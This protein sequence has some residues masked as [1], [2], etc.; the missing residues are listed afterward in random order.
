MLFHKNCSG[1]QTFCCPYTLDQHQP[2]LGVHLYFLRNVVLG[3]RLLFSYMESSL[4]N[5]TSSNDNIFKTNTVKWYFITVWIQ[6]FFLKGTAILP[7]YFS[8]SL[9]FL[10]SHFET[11]TV[12][13]MQASCYFLEKQ[14]WNQWLILLFPDF[15]TVNIP[16]QTRITKAG[17]E[18]KRCLPFRAAGLPCTSQCLQLQG[19]RHTQ[20][21]Q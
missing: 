15:K 18:E 8:P 3:W 14:F 2:T 19:S 7:K 21:Q 5:P 9:L 6:A 13:L 20:L 16:F 4:L 1:S 17:K 11:P 12:N 10:H